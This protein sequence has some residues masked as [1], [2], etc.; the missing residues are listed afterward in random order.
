[1]HVETLRIYPLKSTSGIDL[2]ESVVEAG[3]LRHDRRWMVV[4]ADGETLTAR[5]RRRLLHVTATPIDDDGITLSAP[6]AA[7]LVVNRP[8]GEPDVQLTISRLE[9]GVSA[10]RAADDWMSR[11]LQERVRVV[12]LDRPNRRTV[13]GAHGG[14]AGDALSLAD[15]GPLLLTTTK[16]LSQLN[17]WITQ[18]ATERG[19]PDPTPLP[20]V[21][22]RPNVVIEE[23]PTAFIEDE[24]KRLRIGEV[25]LR[26]GEHCD[27]CVLTTIDPVTLKGGKEPI[28]TL[29]RQR[30]WDHHVY[31]G[32]RLIPVTLG[33]IRRGDR[34]ALL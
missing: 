14:R 13:G 31:F 23:S 16:S 17:A 24:W 7:P 26:L 32:V 10:G 4:D 22:F 33:V 21:R 29:A 11:H 6:G 3:G 2:D 5:T 15:A 8:T 18:T 1:M 25:E 30:H 34:V 27:R 12:W 20:M 9:S 19:A 28:R